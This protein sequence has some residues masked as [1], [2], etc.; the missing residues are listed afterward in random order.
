VQSPDRAYSIRRIG[1][2][3][4]FM[5][6]IA[7]AIVPTGLSLSNGM[8][9]GV[10]GFDAENGGC[11]SCHG[12]QAFAD[13]GAAIEVTFTDSEGALLSGPYTH[14]AV[15]TVKVMLDEQNEAGAANR[16]GFNFFIDAGTLAAADD[17]VQILESGEATHTSAAF[18][19]WSFEWTAPAEGAA[20]WRLFVNDVD[21]SGLP[22]EADQVYLSGG[23]LT[24]GDY[25]MP[26]A[27]E[28]AEP[29]VGVSLPQYWLGLIA[30][31]MM[32]IIIVFSY[33]YLKYSSPHNADHKD[34]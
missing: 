4:A 10:P 25:A 30:L 9:T 5:A 19:A 13:Q 28:Q 27:M 17:T 6:A 12:G 21:G 31:G 20:T 26:G 29:H 14:D 3:L 16:A 1:V 24:D 23:W 32:A 15:Y 2:A 8:G 18:A 34:R 7:L 22:D 11:I 33:V